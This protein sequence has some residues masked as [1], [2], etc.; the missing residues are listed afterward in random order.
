MENLDTKMSSSIFTRRTVLKQQ[1]RTPIGVTSEILQII[2]DAGA[3]GVIMAEISR[4]ANLSYTATIE[5]CQRLI[6][7]S[8]IEALR[9]GRNCV[10]AITAKG[11]EF[12]R[13]FMTFHEIAQEMNLRL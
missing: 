4:R 11:I 10:L 1:Y 8:L 6:D 3:N 9:K 13:E 7:A 5:N 12:F 2:V